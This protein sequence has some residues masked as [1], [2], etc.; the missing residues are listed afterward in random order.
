MI[1]A[2]TPEP[3]ISG[4][5]NLSDYRHRPAMGE[6]SML[7]DSAPTAPKNPSASDN[8]RFPREE[9]KPSQQQAAPPQKDSSSIFVAAMIAGALSPTPKSMEELVRRIGNSPI[10]AESEA[11][12]KDLIA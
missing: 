4:T 3:A 8:G 5:T 9:R 11:R 7:P 12:L 6:R 2:I 10:P 1:S